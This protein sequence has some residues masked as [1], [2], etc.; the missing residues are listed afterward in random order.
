LNIN[1]LNREVMESGT[2][3]TSHGKKAEGKEQ[4]EDFYLRY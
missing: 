3:S 1:Y 2:G 4:K